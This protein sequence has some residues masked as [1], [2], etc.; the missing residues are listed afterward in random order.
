MNAKQILQEAN[1]LK[2][3]IIQ[4][5]RHLHQNP[6]T[7]FQL[8]KTKEYVK[9]E[10]I[11]MGYEPIDCGKMGLY[12]LAGKKEGKTFLIR[13]DMDALPMKEETQLDFKSTNNNMHACG[14]DMHTAMLLGAAQLLKNHENEINGTVKLMFQPAEEIFEGS[15]D[16]IENGILENPK[17]DAAL[18]IHVSSAVLLPTGG[19]VICSPG[20]TAPGAD[21]FEITVQG[22][23]CH[24]SM[25][26]LGIDPINI[27]S[28]IVINLQEI[29]AR[30]VAMADSVALT[31]GSIHGGSAPNIIPDSVSITGSLRTFDEEIRAHIKQ[32]IIDI[33]ENTAKTFQASAKVKYTSGCPAFDNDKNLS[34]LVTQYTTELLADKALSMADLSG[35]SKSA[36]SEDFAYISQKVP[37][38]MI[39]LGAGNTNDGYKY[40][41]HHP[42]V[43]FD[44]D[45]LPIGTAIHTYNA[46]KWLE[47]NK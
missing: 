28:H 15:L 32:R 13:A 3:I 18:M 14:H 42:S 1:S 24:G 17:V 40:P 21:L 20:I 33:C 44:E 4:H 11:K 29:I 37:A 19:A 46:I 8:T 39:S 9:E 23:G 30:E 10:L 16:M 43:E 6:E 25:P 34:Q 12:A 5:R 7:G 41:L 27:A 2:D 45:A 31:I 47:E 35:A 26:Q 38:I 22:K 36:G